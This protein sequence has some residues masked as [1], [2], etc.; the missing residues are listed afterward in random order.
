[1]I[2]PGLIAFCCLLLYEAITLPAALQ[3][4][5]PGHVDE[6]AQLS[7]VASIAQSGPAG[8]SLPAL[9]MLKADLT[10]GFTDQLNYLNHPP[11]YYV[12]MSRLL[13]ADGWPTWETVLVLRLANLVLSSLA[14]ACALAIGL[15][16]KFP[17]GIFAL[18]A[19]MVLVTPV[20]WG[21]GGAINNDNLAILGGALTV[22]GAEIMQS[23]PDSRI[24]DA[25][26]V[27]G[28]VLAT[29]AKLT[30]GAMVGGFAILFLV[31]RA[32][33]RTY[34]SHAFKA[35]FAFLL[36]AAGTPY[37]WFLANYGSPAPIIPGFIDE[38]R[39]VTSL[40]AAHPDV[41]V[42]GWQPDVELGFA[43]YAIQFAWWL[44]AD[45]DP[46]FSSSNAS[47]VVLIA[48]LM[49]LVLAIL[50]WLRAVPTLRDPVVLA[51][52]AAI[53]MLVP[54]HL[55][56]SWRMH[57][58]VGS[59]PFDAVPRYY[60]PLSLSVLPL[61]ACRAVSEMPALLRRTAMAVLAIGLCAASLTIFVGQ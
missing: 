13:P 12:L 55:M 10:P 25:S 33:T 21:V 53:A 28:S 44:L 26:L 11:F 30:A 5:F 54:L 24:G 37:L 47:L 58:L 6:L 14:V 46:V 60:L 38:Y 40:L 43:G 35:A 31:L 56:F 59:P 9:H 4:A 18:Y 17:P 36:L 8:A 52:G 32:R 7:Y 49:M 16:R 15:A 27:I 22:L 61:A 20:L 48:P 1:V 3:G 34:S 39:R 50:A 19:L 2:R 51:G 57:R 45:W 23:R 29:L 41:A 42:H